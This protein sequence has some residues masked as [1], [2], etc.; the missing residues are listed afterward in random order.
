MLKGA[1]DKRFAGALKNKRVILA[2]SA[3]ISVYRIPDLVRDLRREG[4]EVIVAM[5]ENSSKFV[6]PEIM[7][8]ASENEV[9]TEITGKIEHIKLFS[10]RR[11]DTVLLV[12]PASYDTIGKMANGVSDNVPSLMFSFALG[13]G[14]KIVVAPAMHLDMMRNPINLR[15][16]GTLKDNG[17]DVLEPIYSEGKAKLSENDKIIDHVCRCFYGEELK[18]R[19]VMIISGRGDEPID[20]VRILTNK[21]TGFTGYWFSRNAFRMGAD[22]ITYVGNSNY[23]IPS[24]VNYIKYYDTGEI[25]EAVKRELSSNKYDAVLVPASL[26]DYVV[27]Q[28]SPSKLSGSK[29][30]EI[31][32]LPREKTIN[33]IREMFKGV[34]VAYHLASDEDTTKIRKSFE[35]SRPDFIIYNDYKAEAGPFG[36]VTNRFTIITENEEKVMTEASKSEATLK[37]LRL[38]SDKLGKAA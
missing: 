16:V 12:A 22:R 23:E 33:V 30:Q 36:D 6:S 9:I 18:G 21:G 17:V 34:L 32:L 31:R 15:N 4:A 5:S 26:S 14:T 19:S 20:P 13:H 35:R 7:R 2:T 10:G 1:D 24:Y 38:V 29:I 3:S 28:K 11:D 27:E 37:I 25:T 8:W